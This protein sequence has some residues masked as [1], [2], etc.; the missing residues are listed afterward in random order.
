MITHT[1][2]GFILLDGRVRFSL[3]S[4]IFL[5]MLKTS[6]NHRFKLWNVTMEASTTTD[7]F[8]IIATPKESKCV[9]HAHIHLSKMENPK[10]W[11]EQSTTLSARSY[12][13]LTWRQPT[14]SKPYMSQCTS[15]TFFRLLLSK[16]KFPLLFFSIKLFGKIISK[17]LGAS[18]FP[19][20]AILIFTSWHHDPQLASF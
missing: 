18:V 12:F 16:V 11:Y 19:T 6:L 15:W 14:G 2:C 20:W 7:S 10:G 8:M 3:S 5:T 4:N 1:F 17:S 9:S 13:K